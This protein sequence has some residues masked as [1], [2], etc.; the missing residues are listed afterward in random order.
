MFGIT[1]PPGADTVRIFALSGRQGKPPC[2]WEGPPNFDQASVEAQIA[3]DNRIV[4]WLRRNG[5]IKDGVA[6]LNLQFD[7]FS[8]G[9]KVETMQA[10]EVTILLDKPRRKRG[11]GD[12]IALRAFD[13]AEGMVETCKGLLEERETI[14]GRL[15]E[16][17]LK[18]NDKPIAVDPPKHDFVGEVLEKGS[19]FISLAK[20]FRELKDSN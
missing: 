8:Q 18:Y 20:V 19:Q 12:E 15:V 10:Q 1:F 16:R 7:L 3:S 5:C 2:L 4:R 11:A 13:L 6:T 14:I 17:G 9:K